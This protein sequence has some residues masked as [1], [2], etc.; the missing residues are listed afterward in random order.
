MSNLSTHN[1]ITMYETISGNTENTQNPPQAAGQT[2]KLGAPLSLNSSGYAQVWDG[3]TLTGGI[4]SPYGISEEA[5][6]NFATAGEGYIANFGQ[7]GPPWSN[8][9]IGAP[10]NQPNAVTIPYGAPFITGGVLTML[11]VQ[12]TLFKAQV[13][14]SDPVTDITSVTIA[15]GV[16]TFTATNTHY[17]GEQTVLAGFPATNGLDALNGLQVTVLS[18]GLS[19]TAYEANV[20]SVI[21]GSVSATTV[22]ATDNP[23]AAQ[24]GQWNV[25]QKY[26]LT[27]DANG[28]WYIDLFKVTSGTNTAV[29]IYGMYPADVTQSD[30]FLE[31][32]NG[33]LVFQFIES[34]VNV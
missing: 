32:E 30:A 22:T 31:V 5:G 28:G 7:Q 16:A 2:F 12:D 6:G 29:Q 19:G 33:Q 1:P 3:S 9:N 17:A 25:G 18:S 26:G 34:V 24:P 15:S 21:P 11:A 4:G 14:S 10:P 23:G 8:F 13:D 27:V 20:S